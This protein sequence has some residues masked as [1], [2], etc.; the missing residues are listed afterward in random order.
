MSSEENASNT[1][2]STQFL[3]AGNETYAHRRFGGGQVP[4]AYAHI[5][6]TPRDGELD[7]QASNAFNPLAPLGEHEA[8]S[9]P[10][11]GR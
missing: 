6:A 10:A 7:A 1:T 9:V 8:L 11:D 3:Q 2:A 5:T 4:C